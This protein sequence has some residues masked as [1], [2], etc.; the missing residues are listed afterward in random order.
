V[1]ARPVSP[2]V[3][4]LLADTS[5]GE[6][7]A[8]AAAPAPAGNA[9]FTRFRST[10]DSLAGES[11]RRAAELGTGLRV[12]VQLDA[13]ELA[14]LDGADTLLVAPVAIGRDTTIRYGSR[15]WSFDT[16]RGARTVKRKNENP[17]WIP[18][19]WH[20]VEVAARKGLKLAYLPAGKPVAIG[21]GRSLAVRGGLAGV[22]EGKRFTALPTDEEIVFGS[23]LYVPPLGSKN[24]Q[25][26]GE[27]GRFRL[28]LGD[29]YQLHGTP[30]EDTIGDAATARLHPALRRGHRVA[31]PARAARDARV[32]LLIRPRREHRRWATGRAGQARPSRVRA[33]G[34]PSAAG[35]RAA[36]GLGGERV[37]GPRVPGVAPSQVLAHVE[38]A[39]P[40]EAGEVPRDLHG[41]VGGRQEVKRERDTSARNPRCLR[42][43]E[44]LWSRT[45]STGA[46]GSA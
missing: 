16:P 3:D 20:Y 24:R 30:H 33:R 43:T 28:D 29:G 17:V 31:L 15:T 9:R 1:A 2:V 32:H 35:L 11:A 37:V 36:R 14:V 19:D 39:R 13:R 4:A 27:L 42:D 5:S 40:P 8:A 46:A 45:A 26:E 25:I 10:R 7:D 6:V 41:A 23:T 44:E 18:P 12:V 21:G 34:A 22:L 38:V